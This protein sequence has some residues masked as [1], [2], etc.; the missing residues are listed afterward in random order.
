[1]R[2]PGA[3]AA[4]PS[5]PG[6]QMLRL[7][8]QGGFASVYLARHD[9]TKELRAIKFGAFGDERRFDREMA[10]LQTVKHRNLGRYYE[11]GRM[12]NH[13]WIAME[14]LGEHT[15][16]DVLATVR[17]S[18]KQ[19]LLMALQILR[20]LAALHEQNIIHRDLKPENV[21]LDADFRLRLIDFGLVKV[22]HT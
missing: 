14:Y 4:M 10:V 15:L 8:G 7:L 21:M 6:Y 11:H 12:P 2:K 18:L 9:S 17:P 19:V 3:R 16:A 13:Y 20:G 1:P 5:I 22:F